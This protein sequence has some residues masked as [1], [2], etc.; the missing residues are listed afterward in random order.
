MIKAICFDLWKTLAQE[1]LSLED[2]WLPAKEKYPQKVRMNI[3][4]ELVDE[5]LMKAP[6]AIEEGVGKILL[7][8]GIKDKLLADQISE[9]WKN[10]C[11]KVILFGDVIPLLNWLK[12]KKYRLALIT[13]TSQYGWE[14]VEQKYKL[15]DYFDITAKSFE[16]GT[17]KP[18][19][20]IFIYTERRLE[21]IPREILMVGDSYKSDLQPAQLRQWQVIQLLRQGEGGRG[22]NVNYIKTLFEIKKFF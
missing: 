4:R 19:Q 5:I 6:L 9:R 17:V 22:Q 14:Q 3:V 18:E 10:S 15:S 16:L 2:Y 21:V 1:P 20:D 11:K 7:Y 8:F 12:Q 13:N